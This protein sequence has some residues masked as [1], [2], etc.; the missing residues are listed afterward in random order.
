MTS[1]P[2]AVNRIA[3]DENQEFEYSGSLGQNAV[4]SL[5]IASQNEGVMNGISYGYNPCVNPVYASAVPGLGCEVNDCPDARR[6]SGAINASG[7]L[8][9][10][11][12]LSANN[13]RLYKGTFGAEEY[14]LCYA[15]GF[16]DENDD[17]W[18]DSGIRLRTS[19][20]TAFSTKSVTTRTYGQLPDHPAGLVYTIHGVPLAAGST[21]NDLWGGREP[22]KWMS[23]IRSNSSTLIGGAANYFGTTI[24]NPCEDVSEADHAADDY[25][26]GQAQADTNHQISTVDTNS[27][28]K[29]AEFALCYSSDAADP[30]NPHW[31]DSGIRFTISQLSGI[32]YSGFTAATAAAHGKTARLIQSRA[33]ALQPADQ[34]VARVLPQ[35]FDVPLTYVG[36]L[37]VASYISLVAIRNTAEYNYQNP[38]VNPAVAA[39][40]ADSTHSGAVAGCHSFVGLC[41]GD[42]QT[43]YNSPHAPNHPTID[44][45]TGN[46][47]VTIP[48]DLDFLESNQTFTVCYSDGD[49]TVNDP[50]WRDS[51]IH[52]TMSKIDSLTASSVVHYDH[53][54]V[55]DHD[56][57]V[58]LQAQYNGELAEGALLSLVDENLNS[59]NPCIDPTV[60]AA[61]AS[62]QSTG[63]T[64]ADPASGTVVPLVTT[65][66]GVSYQFALCYSDDGGTTYYDS[67]IRLQKSQ[68]QQLRYNEHQLPAGQ[69]TRDMTSSRG[70]VGEGTNYYAEYSHTNMNQLPQAGPTPSLDQLDYRYRGDLDGAKWVSFVDSTLNN[71]EPCV[72]AAIAGQAASGQASGVVQALSDKSFN[73]SHTVIN[74]LDPTKTFTLCYNPANG[75]AGPDPEYAG[76]GQLPESW[77][78]SYI[79]MSVSQIEHIYAHQVEHRT[80]GHIANNEAVG[81]TYV[82][83]LAEGSWLSLVATSMN[84]YNPCTESEVNAGVD[85]YHTGP[86][87][88]ADG[89]K[90]VV[91]DTTALGSVLDYAICFKSADSDTWRD[92]GIQVTVAAVTRLFYN[93][94][95]QDPPFVSGVGTGVYKRTMTS[96]NT[97]PATDALPLA[98]NRLP[99]KDGVALSFTGNVQ[100]NPAA[101]GSSISKG[102]WLS[103]VDASLN[104]NNPCAD[105][106]VAGNAIAG[107]TNSGVIQESS[108]VLPLDSRELTLD[109]NPELTPGVVLTL[110]YA[111]GAT[112]PDAA[113]D[114]TENDITWRDSYIR[115]MISKVEGVVSYGVTHFTTGMVASKPMLRLNAVGTLDGGKLSLVDESV[116]A[117]HPCQPA[118]ASL[119]ATSDPEA[120]SGISTAVDSTKH[121]VV[122]NALSANA[123]FAVCYAEGTGLSDDTTW[124]DSGIR[125][126]TPRVTKVTYS[127]PLREIDA[128]SCFGDLDL[129][130]TATCDKSI[131]DNG[132]SGETCTSYSD[133]TSCGT[134]QSDCPMIPAYQGTVLTFSGLALTGGNTVKLSLVEQTRG[135]TPNNPCRDSTEAGANPDECGGSCVDA[136]LHSGV[137]TAAA[138]GT[139]TIPQDT[140]NLLDS[141]QTFALC[142]TEGTGLVNDPDWRDSYVR[143]TIS[144]MSS[145]TAADMVVTTRGMFSNVP[146]LEVS[147]TGSLGYNKHIA[148][149][150]S[151][152]NSNIPCDQSYAGSLTHPQEGNNQHSGVVQS[153]A[154]SEMVSVDTRA[155]NG[156]GNLY[157]VCYSSDGGD[158]TATWRDSG[159]RLRFVEWSNPSKSRTVSGSATKLQLRINEGSFDTTHDK[160]ALIRGE[161]DCSQASSA[162]ALSNG[163][164]VT[165]QLTVNSSTPTYGEITL[166]SG[167]GET[168]TYATGWMYCDQATLDDG[169]VVTAGSC[170]ARGAYNDLNLN[171]GTF[172]LCVCDSDNGNGGCDHANEWIKVGSSVDSSGLRVIG[173]PRLGRP[174]DSYNT[175]H[176]SN[177]HSISGMSTVYNVRSSTESGYGVQ[178]SDLIYFAAGDCSTIPTANTTSETAVLSLTMFEDDDTNSATFSAARVQLPVSPALTDDAGS[179]RTLVACFATA[180]SINS[181]LGMP[182]DFV[183]LEDGL[184]V[185]PLPIAGPLSSTDAEQDIKAIS[186]SAPSFNMRWLRYGDLIFFKEHS[187]AGGADTDCSLGTTTAAGARIIPYLAAN[188]VSGTTLLLGDEF[189]EYTNDASITVPTGK[190]MLP[191][192]PFLESTSASEPRFLAVCLIP[193]GAVDSL[194]SGNSCPVNNPTDSNCGDDLLN[195]AMLTAQLHIFPEPISALQLS[196]SAGQIYQLDFNQPQSGS[197]GSRSFSTGEAGDI[198]LLRADDCTGVESIVAEDYFVGSSYSARMTLEDIRDGQV[199]SATEVEYGGAARTLTLATGKVNELP[200]GVY[201]LCYASGS[202]EGDD[203]NDFKMLAAEI[204]I[205]EADATLPSLSIATTILLGNQIVVDWT[206]NIGYQDKLAAANSWIGLYKAG[207]CPEGT[208]WQHRCYLGAKSIVAGT[209]SGQVSF[210]FDEYKT[211]GE[212]DVRYFSGDTFD[213]QGARCRGLVNS[214]HETYVHCVLEAV[215]TSSPFT[216]TTK[217]KQ[218]QDLSAINGLEVVFEGSNRGRFANPW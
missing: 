155:L 115:M 135:V 132:C 100:A 198:V 9:S 77:K 102:K 136:R 124:G 142:Y 59:N 79:R 16:G 62:S 216:V 53:G 187:T 123:T 8:F 34:V 45:I 88:A 57:T 205:K 147:W 78:D 157:V 41:T 20:V 150:D 170:S 73:F 51:Y 195:T 116:N 3:R 158:T 15:E 185:T 71:N 181:G 109:Q 186:G 214:P 28:S 36:Q 19:E 25:H 172:L 113:N 85:S 166:P 74:N 80:Q 161:S 108:G 140:D 38:C 169:T 144:Q 180:E 63:A 30:V 99:Q 94:D 120:Y 213:G 69:F 153:G 110:C 17:T 56:S 44:T 92:S 49:G 66:L 174:V 133:S 163:D 217:M 149:I 70:F 114:G 48:Q 105:R 201:K 43:R 12:Q 206:S 203:S 72:L 145:L 103:F 58:P 37:P 130:G 197:F 156:N 107:T 24:D 165:R 42:V 84:N 212:F 117:Y 175:S 200:A 128:Q 118:H 152:Q 2:R 97:Y 67:G 76:M 188:A 159:I 167:S 52:V 86:V 189:G 178:S 193:A 65:D 26:S 90:L 183:Q 215:V 81:L 194:F 209:Q 196:W 87:Q 61:T 21:A 29:S 47:E 5:V 50:N 218:M 154:A 18:R 13:D 55:A 138:D 93:E 129:Y 6:Y 173:T 176:S 68:L 141:S 46:K 139:F 54:M 40:E 39:A 210:T 146:S 60:A 91:F 151:T 191:S 134:S 101:I 125:L 104:N 95:Q 10:V 190:V 14:A 184:E 127:S 75:D 179:M 171:E 199:R 33:A 7:T 177:V 207:E 4:L 182:Q 89:T 202:S 121:T 111:L 27:I 31:W 83:S 106:T 96:T 168:K 82:G 148:I 11:P 143:L 64:A 192:S 211:A 22:S 23:L 164:L 160:V 32:K 1:L 122:T 208:E 162:P 137:M 119:A 126:Q 131:L 204:E 98:T 112:V 35:M